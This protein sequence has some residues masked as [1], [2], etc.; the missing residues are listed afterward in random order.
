[1][2]K[3]KLDTMFTKGMLNI[4]YTINFIIKPYKTVEKAGTR[5]EL[6]DRIDRFMERKYGMA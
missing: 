2:L 4:I 5:D 1:M 6:N 3:R